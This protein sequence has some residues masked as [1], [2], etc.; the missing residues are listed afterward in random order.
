MGKPSGRSQSRGQKLVQPKSNIK[1][2]QGDNVEE[3]E[4]PLR[5]KESRWKA[6]RVTSEGSQSNAPP[7]KSSSREQQT[8]STDYPDVTTQS[9]AQK[10]SNPLSLSRSASAGSAQKESNPVGLSRSASTGSARKDS[11]PIPNNPTAQQVELLRSASASS[12][13]NKQ[14]FDE[15]EA[16]KKRKSRSPSLSDGLSTDDNEAPANKARN[17]NPTPQQVELPRSAS[18]SSA[19]LFDEDKTNKKRKSRSHSLSD[20]ISDDNEA[21]ANNAR[22]KRYSDRLRDPMFG[23]HK[24]KQ[25]LNILFPPCPRLGDWQE[26]EEV[27][28]LKDGLRQSSST[29]RCLPFCVVYSI[30]LLCT[31]FQSGLALGPNTDLTVMH[32]PNIRAKSTK[33]RNVNRANN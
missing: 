23:L 3:G 15:D 14:L 30:L 31:P 13:K 2:T 20:D 22:N 4:S 24:T 17:N 33:K 28:I 6:H 29:V 5:N 12:A 1:E 21:A 10:A 18:A 32:P 26:R 19:K 11:T 7:R 25:D 16:N 27:R 8:P 9:S